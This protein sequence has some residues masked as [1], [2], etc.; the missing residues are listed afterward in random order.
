MRK[1]SDKD[2]DGDVIGVI[3]VILFITLIFFS[4]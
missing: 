2:K 3:C 1:K 4:G